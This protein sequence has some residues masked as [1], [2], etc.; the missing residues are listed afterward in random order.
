MKIF[1]ICFYLIIIKLY[2]CKKNENLI[3]NAD[4]TTHINPQKHNLRN[5]HADNNP[6]LIQ[7]PNGSI[8]NGNLETSYNPNKLE[9]SQGSSNLDENSKF[10]NFVESTHGKVGSLKTENPSENPRTKVDGD[11]TNLSDKTISDLSTNNSESKEQELWRI[12]DGE[13]EDSEAH[14]NDLSVIGESDDTQLGTDHGENGITN[15]P[16]QSSEESPSTNGPNPVQTIKGNDN[17]TTLQNNQSQ[18][19]FSFSSLI[20]SFGISEAESLIKSGIDSFGK[21]SDQMI[22][23]IPDKKTIQS[24]LGDK[25]NTTTNISSLVH[26]FL[27][28]PSKSLIDS[29][30]DTIGKVADQMVNLIPEHPSS[31]IVKPLEDSENGGDITPEDE[32]EEQEEEEEE[33]QEEQIK[34]EEQNKDEKE[35]EKKKAEEAEEEDEEEDEEEE[36][37][38]DE[39]LIEREP[40]VSDDEII[41]DHDDDEDEDEDIIDDDEKMEQTEEEEPTKSK[42]PEKENQENEQTEELSDQT[43]QGNSQDSV[44]QQ[45]NQKEEI[46]P[47]TNDSS[48]H[49]LLIEDFKEDNKV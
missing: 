31:K 24:A 46:K 43:E 28:D 18:P 29:G 23:L 22:D 7:V 34:R 45:Q 19:G 39:Q 6:S 17:D 48:A 25:D 38:E 2:M 11:S 30:I 12:P 5:R 16:V 13:S 9:K 35:G 21:V 44:T 20:N 37:E 42:I 49:K 15:P 1:N 47:P 41:E 40:E 8:G 33:Q 10:Q 3:N 14:V 26:S 4:G 36:D 27:S 32:E